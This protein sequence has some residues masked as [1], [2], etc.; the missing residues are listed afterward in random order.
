M[1]CCLSVLSGPSRYDFFSVPPAAE[2]QDWCLSGE[3]ESGS[4]SILPTLCE[5]FLLYGQYRVE[6]YVS[7]GCGKTSGSTVKTAVRGQKKAPCIG[8]EAIPKSVKEGDEDP[9]AKDGFSL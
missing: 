5:K 1:C 8:E 4:S 6:R 7:C 3:E 2:P 9:T